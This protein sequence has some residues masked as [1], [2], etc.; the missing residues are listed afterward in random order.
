MNE[1]LIRREGELQRMN[2]GPI[3]FDLGGGA[4]PC[5][6]GS[7]S[8]ASSSSRKAARSGSLDYANSV[9]RP[10]AHPKRL[11]GNRR[12]LTFFALRSPPNDKMR[13]S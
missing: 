10:W 9:A 2:A 11:I 12:M 4:R 1:V 8:L 13:S 7:I 3:A 6:G 5:P